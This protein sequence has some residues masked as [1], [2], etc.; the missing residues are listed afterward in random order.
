MSG[1]IVFDLG[2]SD[3]NVF[4]WWP[5]AQGNAPEPS[6]THSQLSRFIIDPSSFSLDLPLPEVLQ[7]AT[8]SFTALMTVLPRRATGIASSI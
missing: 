5:D 4:F 6:S 2:L 8:Q 7:K 1:K 3:K